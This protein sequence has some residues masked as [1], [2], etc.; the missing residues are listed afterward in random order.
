MI[1][2]LQHKKRWDTW[3]FNTSRGPRVTNRDSMENCIDT[4]GYGNEKSRD[5]SQQIFQFWN[6]FKEN[7][8]FI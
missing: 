6:F 1:S 2:T 4:K 5:V 7:Y 8:K 3:M